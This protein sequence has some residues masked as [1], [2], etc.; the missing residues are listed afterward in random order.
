MFVSFNNVFYVC[1]KKQ[2][3]FQFDLVC[4]YAIYPTISLVILNIGSP[5]GV[6]IFGYLNDRYGRRLSFF[7]CLATLII[8]NL[9]TSIAPNYGIWTASRLIVGLNVP[10]VYQIPFIIG[11]NIRFL[12]LLFENTAM[13]STTFI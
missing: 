2:F 13:E 5:V 9:I 8:G 6:Y 11:M 4:D 12:V 3:F 1:L 10:A 7:S